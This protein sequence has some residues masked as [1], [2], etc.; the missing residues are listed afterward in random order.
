[1]FKNLCFHDFILT[2]YS[3]SYDG[4][5]TILVFDNNFLIYLRLIEKFYS[6]ENYEKSNTTFFITI[7]V[8]D[9]NKNS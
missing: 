4:A 5:R 8:L 6:L 2:L 9:H 1:M 3:L 7:F